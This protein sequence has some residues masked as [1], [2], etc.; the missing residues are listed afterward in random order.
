MIPG[1]SV[2]M[3]VHNGQKYLEDS[4]LSVLRQTYK[5]FELIIIN[6]GS[7]DKSG[8]IITELSKNN[9]Q[10]IYRN[11]PHSGQAK[12]L[13]T[14]IEI[15][16]YP[17]IARI[18]AD[19]IWINHK[20]EVQINFLRAHPEIKLLGSSVDFIDHAGNKIKHNGFNRKK[21]MSHNEIID[22][23]L[24]YN[25]FCH[26]SVIFSKD[27]FLRVGKYN[28][29]YQT[30]MDYD[31]WFRITEKYRSH[32]LPDVL[33]YYRLSEEMISVKKRKTLLKESLRIHIKYYSY[34]QDKITFPRKI[35]F[36]YDIL[37][38]YLRK[39]SLFQK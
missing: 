2:V 36:F 18:D 39:I 1:I 6:D 5:L 32:I 34:Y 16:Q 7:T 25:V 30:S 28:E 35:R 9:P 4:I 12:A 3:T 19:D 14:A 26:S 20:L 31:L 21:E 29:S 11:I 38:L 37:R 22:N 24:R 8:S 23:L 27:I 17:N 15:S 33:T 10:I 13:N